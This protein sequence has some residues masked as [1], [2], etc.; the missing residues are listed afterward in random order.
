[1]AIRIVIRTPNHLGDFI[2]ALPMITETREAYPGAEVTVLIPEHLAS[3][4]TSNIGV[5]KIIPIPAE[6]QHGAIAI[7]KIKAL[8][9]QQTYD[10]GYI[11]PPSFGAAAAFKLAGVKERIAYVADGRRLLLSKP[12]ALP[13]PLN[14]SHRSE[15]YFNLLRRA[16]GAELTYS[17][18]KLFLNDGDI[19]A[20]RQFLEPYNI[21]AETPFCVIGFRSKAES[22]RWGKERY[23][24]VSLFIVETL[25]YQ[26]LLMGSKEDT[27]EGD[28]IVG[29]VGSPKVSNLAGKMSLREVASVMSLGAFFVGDDSGPAH[30]AASVGIP[31]VVAF[32]AGDPRATSP[33]AWN[34][35]ILYREELACISCL[36]N[37]CPLSGENHMACLKGISVE[38]VGEAIREVLAIRRRNAETGER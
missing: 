11:L 3:L 29:Q 25:G 7:F 6:H 17:R 1:M 19:E 26:V 30:L 20:A 16:S 2:M 24:A 5:D 34:A 18:P 33:L 31:V 8:L 32:G 14:S 35:Q 13:E 9:E 10:I 38:T 12:V 37:K 23:A 15:L 28:W 27:S 4:M 36:K 22:R 21:T